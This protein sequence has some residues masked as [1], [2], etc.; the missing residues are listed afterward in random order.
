M[1]S[2]V[3]PIAEYGVLPH[4]AKHCLLLSCYCSLALSLR[5]S[6][7]TVILTKYECTFKSVKPE[8]ECT[9]MSRLHYPMPPPPPHLRKNQALERWLIL[10]VTRVTTFGRFQYATNYII[11]SKFISQFAS[12]CYIKV[13]HLFTVNGVQ[14]SGV[15]IN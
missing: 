3:T 15:T 6:K 2:S 1:K 9:F 4:Y 14:V 13:V 10:K 5:I 8:Y 12:H 7:G 11:N